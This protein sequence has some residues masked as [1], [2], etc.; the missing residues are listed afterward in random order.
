ML[1]NAGS[2]CESDP[3][4]M[5]SMGSNTGHAELCPNL[6]GWP[7]IVLK[8]QPYCLFGLLSQHH[9]N[10]SAALQGVGLAPHPVHVERQE[11]NFFSP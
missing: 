1:C 2:V 6:A 5:L 3:S 10:H 8:G 4:E 11:I 9:N 7:D